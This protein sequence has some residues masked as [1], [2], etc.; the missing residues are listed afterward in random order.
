MRESVSVIA[1]AMACMDLPLSVVVG[2]RVDTED[3]LDLE[4]PDIKSA[5][6]TKTGVLRVK[7]MPT[8]ASSFVGAS[9]E[10]AVLICV[11]ANIEEDSDS[12]LYMRWL[13]HNAK[14]TSIPRRIAASGTDALD[15]H[16]KKCGRIPPATLR[17]G[18][19]FS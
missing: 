11:H 13:L 4:G 16:S 14:G 9:S 10:V 12:I 6:I 1:F 8:M 5:A 7:R 15:G 2:L 17:M 19:M 3:I 18:R